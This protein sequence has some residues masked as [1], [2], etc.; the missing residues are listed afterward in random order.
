MNE[1][2]AENGPIALLGGTF[3][4]VHYGHLRVAEE[5]RQKLGLDRL[6]LLPSGQPP[7]RG[8]PGA[9]SCQRLEMLDLALGEFPNLSLDDRETRRPGP[10]YMVDT[11]TDIRL[12]APAC[13]LLLLIGQ[14]AANQL[15][16]WYEWRQ[17]FSLAHIVVLHRPGVD[18][19]YKRDVALEIRTRLT[20]EVSHL[21][22]SPGGKVLTMDITPVEA[23]ATTIKQYLRE[24]RSPPQDM[25][26]VKVLEYI[27]DKLIYLGPGPA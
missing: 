6:Y 19:A 11:L 13:P 7:H 27:L 24:G 5:A 16:T 25:L 10:S 1:Q 18:V 15:H 17:L 26:P 12:D 8:T 20:F 22:A 3:D 23:S 21:H 14:D 2:P 4:P 9:D